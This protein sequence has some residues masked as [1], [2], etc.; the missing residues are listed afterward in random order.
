MKKINFLIILVVFSFRFV[1]AEVCDSNDIARLKELANNVGYNSNYVGNDVMASSFQEYDVSFYGLT[2]E[3]YITDYDDTFEI[4]SN[5]NTRKFQ[6]GVYDLDIYSTNCYTRLKT[7]TVELPK[8]NEFSL[9]LNC[10]LYKDDNLDVCDPWYQGDIDYTVFDSLMEERAE[11]MKKKSYLD[12]VYDLWENNKIL[13]ISIAGVVV[14]VLV[15]LIYR[16]IKK[17]ELN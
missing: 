5:S 3:L 2:N 1:N 12:Y 16:R 8:F 9:N 15:I 14:I 4:Y 11:K 13:I 6:S 10:A 17:N 7:I